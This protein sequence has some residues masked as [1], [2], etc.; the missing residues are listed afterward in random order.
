MDNITKDLNAVTKSLI[1]YNAPL[2]KK[3]IELEYIAHNKDGL[4]VDYKPTP[5]LR[6]TY[7]ATTPPGGSWKICSSKH[8]VIFLSFNITNKDNEIFTFY[9]QFNNFYY[10]IA[11]AAELLSK[12]SATED[13]AVELK[14]GEERFFTTPYRYP[15][16]TLYT[17]KYLNIYDANELFCY[18]PD[19]HSGQITDG[20]VFVKELYDIIQDPPHYNF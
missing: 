19:Q 11:F 9:E 17:F 3:L 1:R 15:C 14:I 5:N 13:K 10:H 2:I 7:D 20:S 16:G 6:C 18:L 8:D 4:T 12:L